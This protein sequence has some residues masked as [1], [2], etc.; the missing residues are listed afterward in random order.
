MKKKTKKTPAVETATP[1]V[2]GQTVTPESTPEPVKPLTDA[3]IIRAGDIGTAETRAALR[4]AVNTIRSDITATT[5]TTEGNPQRSDLRYGNGR[6]FKQRP[7][8]PEA[9]LFANS[10]KLVS[11][12]LDA[13]DIAATNVESLTKQLAERGEQITKLTADLAAMTTERDATK[14]EAEAI[15]AELA[16]VAGELAVLNATKA[17]EPQPDAATASA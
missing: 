13:L 8:E 12:M 17:D 3:E 16:K 14:S 10:R 7:N 4:K 5:V 2:E 1:T 11:D 9:V 6:A 15:K